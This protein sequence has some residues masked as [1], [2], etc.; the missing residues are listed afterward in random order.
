MLRT[1]TNVSSQNDKP[2]LRDGAIT[3]GKRPRR[4]R[5]KRSRHQAI[6]GAFMIAIGLAIATIMFSLKSVPQ[7]RHVVHQSTS[8]GSPNSQLLQTNQR[9]ST[10]ALIN[11]DLALTEQQ[12]LL[13]ARDELD[14]F[15]L[16]VGIDDNNPDWEWILHP[17]TEA[18]KYV[19]GESFTHKKRTATDV[20]KMLM[21]KKSI[22]D[23]KEQ[24]DSTEFSVEKGYMRVP[25]FWDPQP[26]GEIA[27]LREQYD[28]SIINN[29]GDGVRRYLGNFGQRLMTSQEAKSIGSHVKNG[30]ELLETIFITVASYRD[31]QCSSTV[32]S[33]FS[34]ATHPERVRVAVVDQIHESDKPCSVPP[35]GSCDENPHQATCRYRDQIDYLTVDSGLSV[36]PVFA[37]HLG[38]RLYRGEYFAMQSDAHITFVKGWDNEIIEQWHSANNE[39]AVLSTYLSGVEGHINEE[40]GERI[41]KSRPIMCDSDFEGAGEYKHLRHGQQPEGVPYIHDT[42]ML[43]PYWAAGFS[44][45]RGHFVVN[46]PYDQHLVSVSK[47]FPLILIIII[48]HEQLFAPQSHG[49]FKEKK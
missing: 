33:A 38:H 36:G 16:S 40:T 32:E 29:I 14:K 20:A 17:G 8:T 1:N 18:Q 13:E 47:R 4:K 35:G 43:N 24:E 6:L 15:P 3:K 45:G 30:D 5:S 37:R 7:P 19:H 11:N 39:M 9:P 28:P 26:F 44:F 21:N 42:P 12:I 48:L 2:N 22:P 10:R 46:V 25:K 23:N 49:Y 41:S 34:R 31:W 27:D